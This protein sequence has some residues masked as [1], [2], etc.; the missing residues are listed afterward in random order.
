[1]KKEFLPYYVSRF[2]LSV[3]LSILVWHFT[4]MTF[5]MTFVFFGLFLLYLH[6]GWFS[7]DLSTLLY[8]LRRDSHGQAVQRKALIAAVIL[9]ILLYTFAGSWVSGHLAL[10]IGI[11]TYF[12]AQFTFFIKTQIQEH[13]SNQ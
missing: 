1:M 10:S 4:W 6:S 12:I 9:G 5:L 7:V 3:V 8:P 13:L 2:I 11:I